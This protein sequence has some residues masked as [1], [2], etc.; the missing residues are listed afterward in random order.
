MD[1]KQYWDLPDA[2]DLHMD[3]ADL[4]A[5]FEAKRIPKP[6]PWPQI[7]GKT[8]VMAIEKKEANNTS[9]VRL[10]RII[11]HQMWQGIGSMAI[12]RRGDLCPLPFTPKALHLINSTSKGRIQI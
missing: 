12:L 1:I 8:E 9:P 10:L 5:I 2:I 3:P 6:P 7:K 4:E 11:K